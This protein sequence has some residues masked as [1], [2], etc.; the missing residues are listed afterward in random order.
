MAIFEWKKVDCDSIVFFV[1]EKSDS[2]QLKV[3]PVSL[4]NDRAERLS[5]GKSNMYRNNLSFE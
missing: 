4:Q 1:I 3:V 5:R 2:P